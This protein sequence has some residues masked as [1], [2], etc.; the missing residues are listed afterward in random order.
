[1]HGAAQAFWQGVHVEHG[2]QARRPSQSRLKKSRTGRDR[3][4]SLSTQRRPSLTEDRHG[5]HVEHVEHG[6]H[7]HRGPHGVLQAP[8]QP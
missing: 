4:G 5:S 8:S 7:L 3:H 2:S 1:M 6:E